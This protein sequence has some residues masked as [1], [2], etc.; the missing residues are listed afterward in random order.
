MIK[1]LT[2]E[3]GMYS[4]IANMRS[5]RELVVLFVYII[6]EWGGGGFFKD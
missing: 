1:T 6:C 4:S 5:L 3:I 2:S